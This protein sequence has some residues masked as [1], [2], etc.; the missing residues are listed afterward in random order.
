MSLCLLNGPAPL[1]GAAVPRLNMRCSC[2]QTLFESQFCSAERGHHVMSSRWLNKD[3]KYWFNVN[4]QNH[5]I[6]MWV[7]SSASSHVTTTHYRSVKHDLEFWGW[8]INSMSS[9]GL[10]SCGPLH[11]RS[12]LWLVFLGFLCRWKLDLSKKNCSEDYPH[13]NI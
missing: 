4:H 13:R 7:S 12:D 3:K 1:I 2:Y 8:I 10:S 11:W 6:S 9:L 5:H